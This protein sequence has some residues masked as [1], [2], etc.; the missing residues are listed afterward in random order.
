[1]SLCGVDVRHGSL[2][3]LL[4]CLF[5]VSM[6][7]IWVNVKIGVVNVKIG[8]KPSR[9]GESERKS[10]VELSWGKERKRDQPE[11]SR[12]PVHPRQRSQKIIYTS[13]TS[14]RI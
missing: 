14:L 11:K 1:M 12:V 2:L 3:P 13:H 4:L 6:L 8:V 5:I 10:W 7:N 9:E